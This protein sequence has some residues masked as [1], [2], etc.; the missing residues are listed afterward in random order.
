MPLG[1][2]QLFPGRGVSNT[3]FYLNAN[4]AS[5]NGH[6]LPNQ[7]APSHPAAHSLPHEA[8]YLHSAAHSLPNLAAHFCTAAPGDANC[9]TC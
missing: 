3:S 2:H 6:F 1:T 9:N 7:A 8:A 4:P 5:P